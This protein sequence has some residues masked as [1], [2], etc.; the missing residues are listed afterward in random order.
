MILGARKRGDLNN[1]ALD[2]T[3]LSKRDALA[4]RVGLGNG[5]ERFNADQTDLDRM[6]HQFG[7]GTDREHIH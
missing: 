3:G 4:Q 5:A 6:L 1:S 2:V 7:A